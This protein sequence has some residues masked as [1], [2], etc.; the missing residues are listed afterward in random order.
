MALLKVP[1]H[2]LSQDNQNEVQH[3]IFGHVVSLATASILHDI[4]SI[5]ITT[6]AFVR[7][8]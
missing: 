7:S 5:V 1:M 6:I 8:G 3:D 4:D 2:P